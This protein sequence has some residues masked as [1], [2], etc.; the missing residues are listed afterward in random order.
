MSKI[1]IVDDDVPFATTLKEWLEFDHHK[2][3]V[4]YDP[5]DGHA[6]MSAYT[7]DFLLLDWQLPGMTGVDMCRK[8]RQNNG[9]AYVLML[10]GMSTVEN[11]VEGLEAGADDYLAKPFDMKELAARI[12]ALERRPA[13]YG[14]DVLQAGDLTLDTSSR[15]VTRQGAQL[16]LKPLEYSVLEFFMKH[17]K[18]VVSPD[19]LLK[20]VWDSSTEAS[21]DSVY[22]CINRL[23]KKLND[24]D[25]E[26][27]IKTVHGVGYRFDP[28]AE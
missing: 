16:Q 9:Q 25:K 5:E 18:Q 12:K 4:A 22:T 21:T 3:D 19:A 24:G 26:A 8:Y 1:L 14:G 17:P 15:I 6:F 28:G 23:R 13:R 11:K 20:R 10:T 27:V 7:Y 2:V